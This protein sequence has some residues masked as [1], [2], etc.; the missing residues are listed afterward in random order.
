[1]V[2]ASGAAP[3][4]VRPLATPLAVELTDIRVVLDLVA[5]EGIDITNL[6]RRQPLPL[7]RPPTSMDYRAV[8]VEVS[9]QGSVLH[10]AAAR[11]DTSGCLTFDARQARLDTVL[12]GVQVG[13]QSLFLKVYASPVS[14]I[15]EE[16]SNFV[17]VLECL[18]PAPRQ[19][20]GVVHLKAKDL[21]LIT[22][23]EE[24]APA[25][26]WVPVDCFAGRS[27]HLL[28][29]SQAMSPSLSRS[30]PSTKVLMRRRK[31]NVCIGQALF[32]P[33][34]ETGGQI[35]WPTCKVVVSLGSRQVSSNPLG[36]SC[37]PSWFATLT[38]DVALLDGNAPPM[39]VE[40]VSDRT[41]LA[42]HPFQLTAVQLGT[43]FWQSMGVNSA[44]TVL[45][46]P[47]QSPPMMLLAFTLDDQPP[48]RFPQRRLTRRT[49][50][51]F[52]VSAERTLR[53]AKADVCELGSL[54]AS[55]NLTPTARKSAH[56]V[57]REPPQ[58]CDVWVP[59]GEALAVLDLKVTF[60]DG[61]I[62]FGAFVVHPQAAALV[63]AMGLSPLRMGVSL[64]DGPLAALQ[65]RQPMTVSKSD[66]WSLQPA[67]DLSA[68]PMERLCVV[69]DDIVVLP[70]KSSTL[71]G[72]ANLMLKQLATLAA[73]QSELEREQ[74]ALGPLESTAACTFQLPGYSMGVEAPL[75]FV[76]CR[77]FSARAPTGVIRVACSELQHADSWTP[78]RV[79]GTF[80]LHVFDAREANLGDRHEVKKGGILNL[81]GLDSEEKASGYQFFVRSKS[82]C[83]KSGPLKGRNPVI[84][85]SFE[86]PF[87]LDV[88]PLTIGF[89][90]GGQDLATANINML[91]RVA[92][93]SLKR[94]VYAGEATLTEII[95]LDSRVAPNCTVNAKLEFVPEGLQVAHPFVPLTRVMGAPLE[96][97]VA[98]WRVENVHLESIPSKRKRE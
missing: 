59:D 54:K 79:R 89:T 67:R 94:Y 43:W 41:C 38:L 55:W 32:A 76:P 30:V 81:M 33:L 3:E 48:P 11:A 27:F 16:G 14:F 75:D 57:C 66:S 2:A 25:V 68:D 87:D 63:T 19:C 62:W 69:T 72:E 56:L 77:M 17:R 50:L 24:S 71:P 12:S 97:R 28:Y 73:P 61:A 65:K 91:E 70:G 8:V 90:A 34:L 37:F 42:G 95:P 47:V 51:P 58:T 22:A 5:I 29:A 4:S 9:F 18:Y 15:G 26:K 6:L 40:L 93:P 45:R 53:G 64:V 35:A 1:M 96:V 44:P 52:S 78:T 84:F 60:V 7:P 10:T 46:F 85:Q 88:E 83:S 23:Q 74:V 80:H 20:V 36:A 86:I 82:K 31:V 92:A 21:P 39:Y 49:L 13:S 98:L